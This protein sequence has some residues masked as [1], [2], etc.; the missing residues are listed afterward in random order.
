MSTM[1]YNKQLWLAGVLYTLHNIEESIGFSTFVYPTELPLAIQTPTAS[2]MILAIGLIT[3]IVWVLI[4][5]ANPQQK[6]INK[7]S[8]L[9]IL[10]TVF[11]AN[12]FFPHMAA[13][14]ALKRY[15]PGLITSIILYLPY[16]FWILPKL[17]QSYP[18][19]NQF[20]QTA[21][22]GLLLVTVFV[23]VLQ[24]FVHMLI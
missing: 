17:Y 9:I 13:T 1:N 22:T 24:F 4:L 7:K 5:W 14:I 11:L 12:T 20:Y 3:V 16:S 6:E 23:L 21:I 19:H 18:G 10:S 8:L 2:A 15:F